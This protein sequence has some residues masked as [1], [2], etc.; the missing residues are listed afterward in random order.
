MHYDNEQL[1]SVNLKQQ[2]R[3][4]Y[5]RGGGEGGLICRFLRYTYMFMYLLSKHERNIRKREKDINTALKNKTVE[6][7]GMI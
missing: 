7:C 5:V 2:G 4:A 3:G 6:C 1:V